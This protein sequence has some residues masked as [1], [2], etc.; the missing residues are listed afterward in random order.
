MHE[1]APSPRFKPTFSLAATLAACLLGCF[2]CDG[3]DDDSGGDDGEEGGEGESGDG[4]TPS[5]T[6]AAPARGAIK[7]ILI[8]TPATSVV[9]R[10]SLRDSE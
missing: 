4:G 10:K 5:S 9:C 8:E 7:P 6:S 3:K 2:G 1:L